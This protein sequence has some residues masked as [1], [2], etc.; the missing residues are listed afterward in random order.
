MEA[1]GGNVHTLSAIRAAQHIN[2]RWKSLHLLFIIII[3][4]QKY[5]NSDFSLRSM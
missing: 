2:F 3:H 1:S 5:S 4:E